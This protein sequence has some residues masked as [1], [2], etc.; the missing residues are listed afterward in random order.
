MVIHYFFFSFSQE[1]LIWRIAV[2][3]NILDFGKGY[4][5]ID[6]TPWWYILA[7]E[8]AHW[9]QSQAFQPKAILGAEGKKKL[10]HLVLQQKASHILSSQQGG[11]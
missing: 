6:I 9:L 10:T 5:W 2:V 4:D 8:T 1:F 7:D 3:A 11:A